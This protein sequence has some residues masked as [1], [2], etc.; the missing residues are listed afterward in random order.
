MSLC[1]VQLDKAGDY[2][3]EK[4]DKKREKDMKE[5]AF[6]SC[7]SVKC[8]FFFFP[9]FIVVLLALTISS[10]ISYSTKVAMIRADPY[11]NGQN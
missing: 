2:I 3:K 4:D 1:M 8:M 11:L 9:I 6:C 7:C 10:S 5:K